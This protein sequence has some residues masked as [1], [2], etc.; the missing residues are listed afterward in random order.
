MSGPN[1][2]P[3]PED[4]WPCPGSPDWPFPLLWPGHRA[5][6]QTKWGNAGCLSC[7]N[8]DPI[9]TD[10]M[11]F[12]YQKVEPQKVIYTPT[13][14][15]R[16]KNRGLDDFKGGFNFSLG[17]SEN[18][19]PHVMFSFQVWLHLSYPWIL[20]SYSAKDSWQWRIRNAY[21]FLNI[22]LIFVMLF[23][24]GGQTYFP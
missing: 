18:P 19:L 20:G 12:R 9:S 6:L 14:S 15:N 23:F 2:T 3:C 17:T 24:G 11:W 21:R 5:S 22:Q 7:R 13:W 16:T 1:L 4:F 10:V 8:E